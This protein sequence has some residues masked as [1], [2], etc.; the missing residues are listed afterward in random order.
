MLVTYIIE[1]MQSFLRFMQKLL[2]WIVELIEG[3]L[4]PLIFFGW[5]YDWNY[6]LL[7]ELSKAHIE[8][9]SL[10]IPKT[11]NLWQGRGAHAYTSAVPD[12]KKAVDQLVSLNNA[13][14]DFTLNVAVTGLGLYI[15]VVSVII[16]QFESIASLIVELGLV[17]TAPAAPPTAVV[18]IAKLGAAIGGATTALGLYSTVLK[19]GSKLHQLAVTSAAFAG[20]HRWPQAVNQDSRPIMS[21]GSV[22]DGDAKWSVVP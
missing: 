21:D 19:D 14:A 11:D 22:K 8:L 4:A 15:S 10:R 3:I 18:Q 5:Y 17:A 12:Q 1:A 7:E 2:V 9:E 6:L 13:L 16:I 20:P